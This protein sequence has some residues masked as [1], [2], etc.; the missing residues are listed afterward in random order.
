MRFLLFLIFAAVTVSC[1]DLLTSKAY[2]IDQHVL[3]LLEEKDGIDLLEADNND[4]VETDPRFILS[5]QIRR[6]LRKMALEM[7]CGWPEY[8]IPPLAPLKLREGELHFETGP[9]NTTDKVNRFRVDGLDKF[10]IKKFKL[11]MFTS[12]I[13]FDFLFR[14]VQ[15]SADGYETDTILN[16]L[17]ELGLLVKYEGIGDFNV[18]VKNLRIAGVLNKILKIL[19]KI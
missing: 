19:Y 15:A 11:N 8:G 13:T 16:A 4:E 18:G 6:F 2:D 12:K 5:W 17:R 14:Y 10:K 9:L 3:A 1:K 7:P